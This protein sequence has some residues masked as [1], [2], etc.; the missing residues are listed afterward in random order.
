MAMLP[1]V[2][3]IAIH[4]IPNVVMAS[5]ISQTLWNASYKTY[6]I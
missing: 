4:I 1:Y 6:N 3:I 2:R 5:N